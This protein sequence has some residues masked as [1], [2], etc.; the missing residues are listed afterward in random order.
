MTKN[1]E[2]KF[3]KKL[4]FCCNYAYRYKTGDKFRD[5]ET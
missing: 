5:H 3:E 2:E 4:G 1:E